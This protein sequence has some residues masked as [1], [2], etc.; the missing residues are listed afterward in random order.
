MTY[1]D[2]Q[3][4]KSNIGCLVFGNLSFFKYARQPEKKMHYLISNNKVGEEKYSLYPLLGTD[5]S[6]AKIGIL[7]C[8]HHHEADVVQADTMITAMFH[9]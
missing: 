1:Q 6:R 4:V 2:F 9:E 8:K 5:S 7:P 3:D